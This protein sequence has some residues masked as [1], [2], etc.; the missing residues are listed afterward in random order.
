[1]VVLLFCGSMVTELF[2]AMVGDSDMKSGT[3]NGG[4]HGYIKT[5][6]V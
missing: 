6:V 1:M 2:C 5:S 4:T 3:H